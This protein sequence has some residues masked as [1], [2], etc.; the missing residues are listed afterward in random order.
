MVAAMAMAMEE[1]I[2]IKW[3]I[4]EGKPEEELSTY[5]F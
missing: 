4:R 5:L 1:A 2:R 3:V